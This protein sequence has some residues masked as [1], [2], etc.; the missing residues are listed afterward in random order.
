MRMR[1]TAAPVNPVAAA[2]LVEKRRS[3]R[4]ESVGRR[5]RTGIAVRYVTLLEIH[6]LEFCQKPIEIVVVVKKLD[7][8]PDK[9]LAV[10]RSVA[11]VNDLETAFRHI[12]SQRI[13]D[14]CIR[15]LV[16]AGSGKPDFKTHRGPDVTGTIGRIEDI[17][18]LVIVRRDLVL[19]DPPP[20]IDV[21]LVILVERIFAI[22]RPGFS[23]DLKPDFADKPRRTVEN[24]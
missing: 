10:P 19:V 23:G 8:G 24:R 4:Y 14:F 18:V 12:R 2:V 1:G 5:G 9:N 20:D 16:G 3:Q 22:V 7:V 17:T 11:T 13:S 6:G 15:V 21:D